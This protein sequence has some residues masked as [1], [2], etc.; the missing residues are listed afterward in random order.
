MRKLIS[1]LALFLFASVNCIGTPADYTDNQT[2]I[3]A[4]QDGLATSAFSL[5][6]LDIIHSKAQSDPEYQ[7]NNSNACLKVVLNSLNAVSRDIHLNGP[8]GDI[9][10]DSTQ[11][12]LSNI[13]QLISN[14][15]YF[16]HFL[17]NNTNS[18]SDI[19]KRDFDQEYWDEKIIDLVKVRMGMKP[20]Q[21]ISQYVIDHPKVQTDLLYQNAGKSPYNVINQFFNELNAAMVDEIQV[22]YRTYI[23]KPVF[24]QPVVKN[25]GPQQIHSAL[26]FSHRIY[27]NNFVLIFT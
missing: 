7:T 26:T 22:G 4:F 18:S 1:K 14:T 17:T 2:Y 24:N 25:I 27:N 16:I 19:H 11:Q 21:A 12:I 10:Q 5:V 6:I 9:S 20:T 23:V 15:D 8:I 3:H 13:R